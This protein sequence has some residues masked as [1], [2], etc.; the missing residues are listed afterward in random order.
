MSFMQVIATHK[1]DRVKDMQDVV[2]MCN[3]SLL[4]LVARKLLFKPDESM[5]SFVERNSASSLQ[6]CI[7]LPDDRHEHGLLYFLHCLSGLQ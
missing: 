1:E 4:F 3:N 5:Q 6:V 2:P 7:D